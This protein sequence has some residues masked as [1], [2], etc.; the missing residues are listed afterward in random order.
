SA[1]SGGTTFFRL[2]VHGFAD[3]SEARSLCS[4]LIS[5]NAACYPVTM[6]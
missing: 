5:K 1:S 3:A 4:V 6:N 2:R